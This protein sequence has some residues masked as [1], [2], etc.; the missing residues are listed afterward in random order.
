M[1]LCTCSEALL[2]FFLM[3]LCICS[4]AF[5]ILSDYPVGGGG[6]GS[7]HMLRCTPPFFSDH[8]VRGKMAL[9]MLRSTLPPFI[10]I[11]L[12]VRRGETA[13]CTCS[14]APVVLCLQLK[15]EG[16]VLGH[17]GDL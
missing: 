11:T 13:L 14:E 4:E 17:K 15:G 2:R 6:D 16:I 1:V 12:W 8:L 9:H 10:L 3:A 5:F 7:L